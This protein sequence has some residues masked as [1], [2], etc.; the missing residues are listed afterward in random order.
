[1]RWRTLRRS[2]AGLRAVIAGEGPLRER[3]RRRVAELGLSDAVSLPGFVDRDELDALLGRAS[4]VV[5]PSLR[6]GYGMVVAEAAAAGTPVVVC[7]SPD[8]AAI[9]LVEEG[10][11]GTV[12]RMATPV[13][14]GGAIGRVL[15]GG[16]ELRA[17]TR[18]WFADNRERLS[19]D[20]S[21]AEVKR[22]YRSE[23]AAAAEVA[24]H[25]DE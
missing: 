24:D 18:S 20:G 23:P 11:N 16:K 3:V 19:I 1:M 9:E 12:A 13:E 21:I 4:C 15:D 2:R 25:G 6:D 7:R 8:S 5:A 10:V 17:S 14:I 22:V